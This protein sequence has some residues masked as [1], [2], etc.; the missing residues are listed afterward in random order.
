MTRYEKDMQEALSGNATEVLKSRKAELE[1]L[2]RE[3]KSCKNS[4]R[5]QCLAQEV[6]RLTREYDAID[7]TI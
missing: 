7:E 1:R 6:A 5:R 2:T 3:G 4:F